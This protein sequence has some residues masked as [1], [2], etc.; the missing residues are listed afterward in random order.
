MRKARLVC[1]EC[2][3]LEKGL[4][5][6][7]NENELARLGAVSWHRRFHTGKAIHE[8]GEVPAAFGA[9]VSG[10]VKLMKSMPDGTQQIVGLAGAGDFLGRP[11]ACEARVAAVAANEVEVCWFPRAAIESLATESGAVK[12]WLYEYVAN[13]LEK[14]Q[15]WIVLL[16]RM[17]AEQ[18]VAAFLL[19]VLRNKRLEGDEDSEPAAQEDVTLD[20]PLSRTEMADYLGLTIE[21]VSR[22][23]ARLRERGIVTVGSGRI[24]TVRDAGALLD[25]V[26][27]ALT[28]PRARQAWRA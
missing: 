7:L 13:E 18:K 3:A 21:T 23:I 11:F 8:E 20:L 19:S 12:T 24:V 27:S 4:C 2:P 1:A 26:D 28:T 9:V 14:A 16:G 25:L 17:T 5:G 15:E 10:I 22:Q 6:S